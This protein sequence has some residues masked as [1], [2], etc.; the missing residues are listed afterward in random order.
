AV[1]ANGDWISGRQ[2]V[3]HDSAGDDLCCPYPQPVIGR[4]ADRIGD[5]R[6]SSDSVDG[7][8]VVPE[9]DYGVPVRIRESRSNHQCVGIVVRGGCILAERK[10]EAHWMVAVCPVGFT[11]NSNRY[12]QV[13]LCE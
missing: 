10:R 11:D 7:P 1:C 13:C 4:F 12:E 5:T 9:S 3:W 6:V 2:M 8:G